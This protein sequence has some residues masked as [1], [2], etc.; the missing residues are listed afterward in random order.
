MRVL[1]FGRGQGETCSTRNPRRVVE[2]K[3]HTPET[4]IESTPNQ[5][6][7]T[8]NGEAITRNI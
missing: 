8:V 5:F 1:T 4:L 2:K 3:Q 7:L 6:T